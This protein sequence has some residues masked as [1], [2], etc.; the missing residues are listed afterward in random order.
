VNGYCSENAAD[1]DVGPDPGAAFRLADEVRIDSGLIKG[2]AGTDPAVTIF[3]GIPYAAPPIGDLRWKAPQPV[4]SWTDVRKADAFGNNAMQATP[5]P[6]RW[7]T[8]EFVPHPEIASSEDCLTL[9]LWTDKSSTNG[10]RPV[11]VFIHGGGFRSGAGSCSVYDGEALAK[12]G[13]VVVTINYRLGIFGF[14]AHPALTAESP[15]HASG[16]YAVLDMIAA[17]QWVKRNIAAFGGDPGNVTI[18]GQSAGSS[19]VHL[20]TTSPLAKGLIH[21]AITES[22]NLIT[23]GDT[24]DLATKEAE[25]SAAFG[26]KTL[27]AMR[28]MSA[29]DVMA[30]SWSPQP[31]IDGYALTAD[32]LTTLKAGTQNDVPMISGMVNGD[33]SFFGDG[34]MV[35]TLAGYQSWANATY[36]TQATAF[37]AAYPAADDSAAA[38]QFTA[39]GIDNQNALEYF[40]ARGRALHGQSKTYLYYFDHSMPAPP[41]T[42]AST[43]AFHTSDVPYSLSYFYRPSDPEKLRPWTQTDYDLGDTMSSYWANFAATGDPNG[44]GLPTWSSYEGEIQLQELGDIVQPLAGMETAKASFWKTYYGQSDQLGL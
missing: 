15:N 10:K 6:A 27:D 37:L 1:N 40:L 16:N 14:L 13:V 8:E 21:R 26:A 20:L 31:V 19:A 32:L 23:P 33:A 17:L 9:N 7:W 28:A 38:A 25:G 3:K 4:V 22:L 11:L 24:A 39:S 42:P 12:K 35:T 5:A 2:T 34:A 44:P 18:Q 36:G 41:N 29:P 30:V 43:G